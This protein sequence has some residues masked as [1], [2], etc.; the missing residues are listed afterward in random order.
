[1]ANKKNV[2][3]T[4]EDIEELASAISSTSKKI[5]IKHEETVTEEETEKAFQP[6]QKKIVIKDFSEDT[7]SEPTEAP[8]AADDAPVEEEDTAERT[9]ETESVGVT[10][11]ED[12]AQLTA[13]D[14]EDE[15]PDVARDDSELAAFET[16]EEL[17]LSDDEELPHDDELT[18]T[19]NEEQIAATDTEAADDTIDIDPHKTIEEAI[20]EAKDNDDYLDE[21]VDDT[22]GHDEDIDRAVDEIVRSEGDDSMRIDDAKKWAAT[23]KKK[24]SFKQ[25]I[26][27]FFRGW[28]QIK[29]IR[30]GTIA[31]L[32]LVLTIFALLPTTRYWALNSVGVRVASSVTVID[33]ETRLPLK[34]I[35]VKIQEKAVVTN[36]KGLAT[37]SNLKVGKSKLEITK[38]G[39]ATVTKDVT[40]GW[41]SNPLKNEELLATGEKFTFVLS[42]WLSDAKITKAEATVGESSAIA[43]N[44]GVIVLTVG[45]ENFAELEIR[46]QAEGYREERLRLS[47]LNREKTEVKM[48]SNRKHVFVSNRSGKYDVYKRDLDGKNESILMAATKKERDTPSVLMHPL[49]NVAAVVTSRDGEFNSDGFVYDGLYIVDSESGK[50]DRITRSEQLQLIGWSGDSLVFWQVIE[51]TSA[52]NP[53]RSKLISYNIKTQTRTDL[54]ASNYFNDV[55]LVNDR[56]VYAVSSYAVPA[57]QAKLYSIDVAGKGKKTVLDRQVWDIFRDSYDKLVVSTEDQSWYEIWINSEATTKLNVRPN[58]TVRKYVR[59]PDATRVV[60]A[61]VRD[62]KGVL[63]ESD[64]DN[65]SEKTVLTLPGLQDVL[66]WVNNETIVFR[67]ITSTE[68]ADYVYTLGGKDPLKVSDVTASQRNQRL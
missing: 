63:L 46:L 7:D 20:A 24:K 56:V 54:A 22:S 43:N 64:V 3:P 15:Q 32:L 53:E 33:S 65:F 26:A 55:E 50:Y 9:V 11:P 62:G 47:D 49:V 34:N 44:E 18:D 17:G 39:Y 10:N 67:V 5:L 37:F 12:E 1:M 6:E 16:D 13:E 19:S 28:W 8:E 27:G 25:K 29:P 68:T 30:Y 35:S 59:S 2:E 60:W 58:P 23:T 36:E 51:G 21:I 61:E 42:D 14:M 48:V 45:E 52:G 57:S 66:Y 40:L 4:P 31:A 38:R 41:G